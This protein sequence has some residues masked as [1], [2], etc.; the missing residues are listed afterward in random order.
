V[1]GQP[2]VTLERVSKQFTRRAGRTTIKELLRDPSRLRGEPFWA[3]NDVSF[4]MEEGTTVGVIGANGSGKS[5][6]LRLVAG[7]GKPTSGKITRPQEVAAI[8]T[9]GDAF[10]PLLT[11]RENAITAGILAGFRN[12]DVLSMLPEIVAFAELEDVFDHP[13][14]TYSDGMR[15]RLAFAVATSVEPKVLLID[16]VLSVGDLRFQQKCVGRLQELQAGGATILMASHDDSLVRRFCTEVVWLSHGQVQ[17]Y[18]DPDSVYERYDGAMRAETERR[19]Q[20]DGGRDDT[21]HDDRVGTFEV[22]IADVRV[23]PEVIESVGAGSPTRV[24]LEITLAP[25]TP[26]DD[27]IVSVSLHRAGDYARMLDVST[28]G[29]AVALG[30]VES[31]RTIVLDLEGLELPPGSYRFDI[32]VFERSWAY[33]YDYRWHA[34]PLEVLGAEREG[35]RR[36]SLG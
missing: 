26:V 17:G 31:P 12:R 20:A 8:L 32:G 15:L 29:D 35:G 19:A 6:L 2:A 18:G 13:I 4:E 3:V 33:I 22:E 36:W 24:R 1:R 21:A 30:R 25:R 5:T 34:Y 23:T 16:E 27:P 9:L 10:D 7:L 28:E 14:R 11:G